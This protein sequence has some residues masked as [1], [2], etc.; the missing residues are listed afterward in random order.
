M[1]DISQLKRKQKLKDES[2]YVFFI[3]ISIFIQLD[4]Q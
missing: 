4:N 1:E 3:I 2:N